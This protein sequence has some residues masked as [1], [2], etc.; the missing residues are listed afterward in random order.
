MDIPYKIE[1]SSL[2]KGISFRNTGQCQE[3]SDIAQKHDIAIVRYSKRK[4]CSNL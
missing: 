4:P 1:D 3:C 2:L